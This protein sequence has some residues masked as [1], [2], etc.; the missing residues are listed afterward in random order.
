MLLQGS[1]G[2]LPTRCR[3]QESSGASKD[4]VSWRGCTV[5]GAVGRPSVLFETVWH[6]H[7]PLCGSRVCTDIIIIYSMSPCSYF[8]V[9]VVLLTQLWCQG[10]WG[11]YSW[12]TVEQ[13]S[14]DNPTSRHRSVS[15]VLQADCRP[16]QVCQ[17]LSSESLHITCTSHAH[18]QYKY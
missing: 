6:C 2:G 10:D 7:H 5:G 8:F 1:H 3:L 17:E 12:A 4:S 11:C 15:A 14:A 9:S 16:L 13:G 18:V